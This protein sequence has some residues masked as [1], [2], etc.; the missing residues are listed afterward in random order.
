MGRMATSRAHSFPR[1]TY[2]YGRGRNIAVAALGVLLV[3]GLGACNSKKVSNAQL[4]SAITSASPT[5]SAPAS[6]AGT[7]GG[8]GNVLLVA[9][10]AFAT[11]TVRPGARIEAKDGDEA[12][13]TVTEKG[14]K[15]FDV[16]VSKGESSF[17]NAPSTPG[18]YNLI[19]RFHASMAGTLIVQA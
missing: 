6:T 18:T 2:S 1:H 9:H 17:F 8:S 5:A 15:L 4:P 13:H 19:C 7:G 12:E 3:A 14:S 16:T 10:F 11:L